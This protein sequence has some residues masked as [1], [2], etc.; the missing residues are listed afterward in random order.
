[1]SLSSNIVVAVDFKFL[2][3]SDSK[4]TSLNIF[5]SFK[6]ISSNK[7]DV[8]YSEDLLSDFY[9]LFFFSEVSFVSS[10]PN[11]FAMFSKN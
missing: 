9:D 3:S 10:T 8:F 11:F 2:Y 7:L 1:M 4:S 5:K 6:L